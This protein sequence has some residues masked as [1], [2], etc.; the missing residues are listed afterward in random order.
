MKNVEIQLTIGNF[1]HAIK[2]VKDIYA[3]LVVQNHSK[4]GR[5]KA[6]ALI[7]MSLYPSL[8]FNNLLDKI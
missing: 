8:N 6:N 4:M 5:I 3:S 7:V 2:I 1:L